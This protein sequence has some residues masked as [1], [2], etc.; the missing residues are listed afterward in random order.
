M[1]HYLTE[2]MLHIFFG[3]LYLSSYTANFGNSYL[4]VLVPS[5]AE[6]V[7]GDQVDWGQE[8]H[9]RQLLHPRKH[10]THPLP[11]KAVRCLL[12]E[13]ES[14]VLLNLGGVWWK[15]E[16]SCEDLIIWAKFINSLLVL[17]LIFTCSFFKNL[18]VRIT[19]RQSPAVH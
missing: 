5:L 12:I 3:L 17:T 6:L 4:G 7:Q 2:I 11:P 16:L 1:N 14:P 13:Q 15:V 10:V 9:E 8:G 19:G 18:S